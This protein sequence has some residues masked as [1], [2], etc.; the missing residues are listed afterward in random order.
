MGTGRR[1]CKVRRHLPGKK[2]TSPARIVKPSTIPFFGFSFP[3]LLFIHEIFE[4][5]PEHLSVLSSYRLPGPFSGYSFTRSQ[6]VSV[7]AV[8]N[9]LTPCF[10]ETVPATG[11]PI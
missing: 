3:A 11:L 2:S 8:L 5:L 4:V 10:R 9:R 6:N 1:S 7:A